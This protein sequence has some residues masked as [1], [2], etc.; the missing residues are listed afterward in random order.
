MARNHDDSESAGPTRKTIADGLSRRDMLK[1]SASSVAAGVVA[2]G[3]DGGGVQVAS[4]ADGE[5]TDIDVL[6]FALSLELLET[7]FYAR[8][9]DKFDRQD[10]QQAEFLRGAG[11]KLRSRVF[12]DVSKIRENEDIHAEVLRE[13]I[14]DR[15]GEP[16]SKLEYEFPLDTVDEFVQT[17]RDIE[18]TGVTAYNG[19]ISL[20]DDPELQ[21]KAATIV[22]VEA[23]HGAFLNFLVDRSPFPDA[24]DGTRTRA[25]VLDIVDQ[26]IVDD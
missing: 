20:I 13:V 26:F 24:F 16:V 1:Y 17:A 21:T 15:G 9:F 12:D 14:E 6:N 2:L 22:T 19:A 10:F 5:V 11:D 8:G 23:R 25:E 18:N 7:E 4:A 3:L